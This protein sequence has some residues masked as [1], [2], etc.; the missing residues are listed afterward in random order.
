[1]TIE[2]GDA[3]NGTGLA[4]AIADARKEAYGKKYP[5]KDD[6]KA[7]NLESEALVAQLVASGT[8][9]HAPSHVNGVD[10]IQDATAG[11]KGLATSTQITKLDGI[12]AS[13]DV[14]NMSDANATELTDGSTTVLH[15]HAG[16]G[17]FDYHDTTHSPVA[18][19]QFESDLTDASGNGIDLT[20]AGEYSFVELFPGYGVTGVCSGGTEF[21]PSGYEASLDI[22]GAL[23]IEMMVSLATWSL[24]EHKLVG[25]DRPNQPYQLSHTY[26]IMR[27]FAEYGA[28]TNIS[29]YSSSIP[30][31]VPLHFAFTRSAD[32]AGQQQIKW[33]TNGYET[34]SI[35]V[36]SAAA[37]NNP[38]LEVMEGA[39]CAGTI[40][41]SLK[42]IASELS[43]AQILTE[44]QRCLG[45]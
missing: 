12:E 34:Y 36:T 9:P 40:M 24:I 14:N 37:A 1:M 5:L 23:T 32:V 18:L 19:W 13:A 27:Y 42:I 6:A 38:I 33:Y 15:N 21:V 4:G 10:D 20:C 45:T 16:G 17:G 22:D 44:A 29:Q 26:G 30:I 3:I 7:I 39:N 8:L 35:A 2:A 28:G 11:V 43:A 31:G 25:F 41:A